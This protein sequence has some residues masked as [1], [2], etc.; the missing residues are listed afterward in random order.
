MT[1]KCGKTLS[2]VVREICVGLPKVD[3]G[4]SRGSLDYRVA[5]KTFARSR[6]FVMVIAGLLFCAGCEETA[7]SAPLAI[8]VSEQASFDGRRV[9]TSGTLRE[10][11]PPHHVW[12]EDAG[13]NRVELR[14]SDGLAERVGQRVEVVGRFSYAADV[15]RRIEL[16]SLEPSAT[17]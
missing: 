10:F 8:L 3:G 4:M 12:I 13:L 2:D 6:S 5:G 9:R 17:D 14:P 11:H 1:A 16:E 15:G 7:V